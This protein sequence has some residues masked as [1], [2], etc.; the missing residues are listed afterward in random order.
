MTGAALWL[1]AALVAAVPSATAVEF[2]ERVAV[3]AA[4]GPKV[5]HH[6]ASAGRRNIAAGGGV[7][8]VTWEDDR[9]GIPEVYV[10]FRDD[11]GRAFGVEHRVS[12]GGEAFAP[13]IAA[14]GDGRVLVAWEEGERVWLRVASRSGLGPV[15]GIDRAAARQATL[16]AAKGRAH[17]AWV[18]MSPAG[19]I[20]HHARISLDGDADSPRIVNAAVVSS[21][22]G[23]FFQAYPALTVLDDGAA[24]IVWE[25]R[26]FGHTR[27]LQTRRDAD[28]R[29]DEPRSINTFNT[30]K[31]ESA[32]APRLGSGVMRP[33]IARADRLVAAWLDK[34]NPGGGYAIWGA[35]S[36]NGGRSFEADEKIQD[37]SGGSQAV[38]HWNVAASGHPDGRVVVAWD[39][40]REAWSDPDETGDIFF[41]WNSGGRWSG[42]R[43]VPVA[44]GPGRQAQPSVALDE[45]GDLHLVWTEGS[46]LTGPSRLWY[47][48]GPLPSAR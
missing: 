43:P 9:S 22:E 10:A 36:R 27:L 24:V 34:R 7:V 17:A 8:A 46:I 16:D 47:A 26:R 33:V 1:A 2:G 45:A 30:P 20:V 25:D 39:D 44:A 15:Q 31:A 40:A 12:A 42:D 6:V 35:T 19:P 3:T 5:H 37:D 32:E 28:G 41:S 38:P 21:G 23:R 11:D 13:A 18:R 4:H 48:R 14:L 29:F